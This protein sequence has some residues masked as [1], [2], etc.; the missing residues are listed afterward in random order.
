[1]RFLHLF[2]ASAAENKLHFHGSTKDIRGRAELFR[3]LSIPTQ[4]MTVSRKDSE[5]LRALR[6]LDLRK[7]SLIFIDGPGLYPLTLRYIKKTYPSIVVVY[8][9]H[10]PEFLHRIDWMRAEKNILKK[11]IEMGRA[12]IGLCREVITLSYADLV[13]PISEWDTRFYWKILG[14]N[15]KVLALPY[16][17]PTSY[18]NG[19]TNTVQKEKLCVSLSAIQATP[20]MADAIANFVRIVDLLGKDCGDWKFEIVGHTCNVETTN[21]RVR[22]LGMLESPFEVLPLARAVA[23]LSDYGRGFKTKIMEAINAQAY[24]L[25]T[26]A[27][28][29]RLPAEILPCCIPVR[30]NS[31]QDFRRALEKCME[32]YPKIDPNQLLRSRALKVMEWVKNEVVINKS[33]SSSAASY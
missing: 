2:P 22:V 16:F 18:L 8:R 33:S 15:E 29:K 19:I 27:M 10:N 13:F 7:I 32:P 25:V 31:A 1:M 9:S 24:V 20:I 5:A 17:L 23:V 14:G 21:S 30:I 6:K 11:I 3:A 12:S 4:E 28:L 26:P